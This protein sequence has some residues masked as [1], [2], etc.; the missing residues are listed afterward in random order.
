MGYSQITTGRRALYGHVVSYEHFKGPKPNGCIVRHVCDNPICVQPDHLIIGT[1][2]DN[3]ADMDS[4][5]RR[6]P[7]RGESQHL[8]RLTEAAILDIRSSGE[9]VNALA[10]K[11]GVSHW[12]IRDALK[13][14]TWKHVA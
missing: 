6:K 14:K 12:T 4:R 3:H 1:H 2:R 8:A 5:G 7:A 13:R 10:E 9:S 11:H